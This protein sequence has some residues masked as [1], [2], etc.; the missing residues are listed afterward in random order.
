MEIGIV[1]REVVRPSSLNVHLLKPF[2]ISLLD[3]LTPTTFSPLIL[4]YPMRNTH[5]KGTQISTQLKESL[6]KTLDR[7]YPFAGRVRDNLIINDYDEGVPYIETRVNTHLFEFLQNPPMERLDQ[8]LPYPPFSYQQNPDQVPQAA[9]QLNIFDCGGIAL[10]LC[11][12]HKIIDSATASGFL[13][14][15]AAN[16]RGGYHKA[17]K[18]ENL[19][20]ASMI[21]PPQNLSSNHQYLSLME[22]IWFR[23]AK[24]KTRRFVFDAKA[25]AT[26]RSECKGER[27]PN[28]TRIEAL[29][30]FILKSA[31]LA[32]RSTASSRF[33]LH[34]AVN[35]RRLTEPRLSP[36]SVGNLFLWATAAYNME[37]AAEM[38]L[39]GLVAR[40]KQAV[41]KIN[42]E[43]L[44]T[45]HGDEGFPKVCEY[46][47]RIEEV[48]AH[49]NLEAF[50]FSSWVKFGFNEVDF[51]WGNPIWSGIFGEVGSNSF[52]NLTFFKETRSANYDNAVEAWVTLDEKIMSVLEHDPQFLAFAS[53]NPSII[54]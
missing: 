42:S 9:L 6:S 21:F 18:Y 29:S 20:Q 32:S 5:L 8:C 16:T 15:W 34:Q 27:V 39:H 40:M 33:V 4:F 48:S 28:P 53:P 1:S 19:S 41:G 26:L 17:V 31:M 23:E 30:A 37:H 45:L 36:C 3:Q 52:R 47:K 43:Y 22:K 24:Y 51:G 35:L 14:S 11:L 49:K 25:I 54:I 46:I 2:R 13:R 10:G 38:E 44:K 50:T 7:F 12:S